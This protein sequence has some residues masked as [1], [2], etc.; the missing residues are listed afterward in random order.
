M[1]SPKPHRHSIFYFLFSILFLPSSILVTSCSTQKKVIKAPIKEEGA[2]YLFNKLKQNELKF[3]W[4]TAKFS[5]NYKNKGNKNSFNGQLRIRNDSAIWLTFSPLP[6]IEVFRILLTTDSVK[7]VNRLNDTYF[8]GDYDYVNKYLGTD[9]DFDILQSFLIGNDLSFYE[10]GKFKASLDGGWYKL[11]TAERRKLKKFVRNSEDALK[12]LIQNI[13]IDP[14]NFKIMRADV[15]EI[16]RPNL[17]MEAEYSQFDKV[18]NQLFPRKLEFE[19]TAGN[20]IDV[21]VEFSKITINTPQ[22]FPFKVPAS[23]KEVK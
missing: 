9:I 1:I 17:K 18:D 15:K 2:D 20:N 10:D 19:I 16:V 8:I 7:F 11:S 3:D 6:G 21:A 14:E 22:T 4:L 12:V 23:Y 13:W 5:A